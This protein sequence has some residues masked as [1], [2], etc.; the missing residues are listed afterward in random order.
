M[1]I[2]IAFCIPNVNT[3]QKLLI[4]RNY[5][6]RLFYI[7]FSPF[8]DIIRAFTQFQNKYTF[9]DLNQLTININCNNIIIKKLPNYSYFIAEIGSQ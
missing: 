4:P 8:I 6:F 9:T 3:Y 5:F 2:Y 1:S 7:D